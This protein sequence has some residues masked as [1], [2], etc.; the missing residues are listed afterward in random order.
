MQYRTI[1][2]AEPL[3]RLLQ[4][5]RGPRRRDQGTGMTAVILC[6][7]TDDELFSFWKNNYLTDQEIDTFRPGL[8]ERYTLLYGGAGIED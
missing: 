7:F 4:E 6:H 8:R 2:I 5:E 1:K 3:Y